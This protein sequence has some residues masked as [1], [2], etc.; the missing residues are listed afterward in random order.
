MKT[1]LPRV[2][3]AAAFAAAGSASAASLVPNPNANTGG[4][5]TT[6]ATSTS[7]AA[8][9]KLFSSLGLVEANYK[10]IPVLPTTKEL[11]S[12]GTAASPTYNTSSSPNS[13][14]VLSSP[15]ALNLANQKHNT[16]E[17]GQ[18]SL[19]YIP[20]TPSPT[21]NSTVKVNGTSFTSTSPKSLAASTN[22]QTMGPGGCPVYTAP[23]TPNGGWDKLPAPV[24]PAFDPVKA[25]IFRYRQQVSVN[26]GSW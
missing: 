19:L 24:Y 16:S 5:P 1:F 23:Y 25:N 8:S 12:N 3:V 21:S 18:T 20:A 4:I 2:A 22:G 11:S 6:S 14:Q 17:W 26:L 15:Q 13:F 9:E 10:P 7:D